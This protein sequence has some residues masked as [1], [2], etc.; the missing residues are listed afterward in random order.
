MPCV[1]IFQRR[2]TSYRVPLFSKLCEKLARRGV[3]L[4]VVY[5]PPEQNERMRNDT[6]NLPWGIEVPVRY[7][8]LGKTWAVW[9]TLPRELFMSA[10]LVILPQENA[11]LAN[12]PVMLARRLKRRPVAFWGHGAN[13]QGNPEGMRETIKAWLARQVDW[14]FAYTS[15]SV[16]CVSATGFPTDRITCLNNAVDVEQ[17]ALWREG[18]RAEDREQLLAKLGLSGRCVGVFL[19]S[20]IE[21]KRLGFLFAAADG[22][23]QKIGNFELLL[24]GDGVERDYVRGEVARR[25]WCRWVGARHQEEK[26][27]FLSLGKVLLNPGMVGLGVLDSFAMGLPI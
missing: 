2:L 8:R 19:G 17:L 3:E 14:W 15:L 7:L 25:P 21:E 1:V 22:I 6:G 26:A 11:I 20:L 27:L 12:V 10:D 4:Q 16:A 23:R 24:I 9:H 13:F 5:G 18:I